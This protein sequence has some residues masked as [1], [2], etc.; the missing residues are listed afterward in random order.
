MAYRRLKTQKI[1]ILSFLTVIFIS[2]ILAAQQNSEFKIYPKYPDRARPNDL[3]TNILNPERELWIGGIMVYRLTDTGTQQTLPLSAL[4]DTVTI[5][6]HVYDNKEKVELETRTVH[7]V[8][9]D[10]IQYGFNKDIEFNN[11]SLN[12]HY[13]FIIEAER[14]NGDI[15][16]S[17]PITYYSDSKYRMSHAILGRTL[18]GIL[19]MRSVYDEANGFGKLSFIFLQWM[20]ILAF[21]LII[22]AAWKLRNSRVFPMNKSWLPLLRTS[23]ESRIHEHFDDFSF[24]MNIVENR[25]GNIGNEEE[26]GENER[27]TSG[28][29]SIKYFQQIDADE[30]LKDKKMSIYQKWYALIIKN[31]YDLDCEIRKEFRNKSEFE[32][33]ALQIWQHN[34][35]TQII[36]DLIDRLNTETCKVLIMRRFFKKSDKSSSSSKNQLA[37]AEYP[38]GRIFRAG[39][40]NYEQGGLKWMEVSDEIDRAMQNR[41]ESELNDLENESRVSRLW[42]ISTAAPMVGLFGTAVGISQSFKDLKGITDNSEV[43]QRLSG[44]ILSALWTTIIGLLLALITMFAYYQFSNKLETIRSK[45]KHLF[46]DISEKI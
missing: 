33:R 22:R 26:T 8:K 45:W 28:R 3:I 29:H 14:K 34:K 27:K 4:K 2:G 31:R 30:I 21:F 35:S 18:P 5:T 25:G 19:G 11:L 42:N 9:Y 32:D 12:R 37:F 20:T 10:S 1:L 6:M 36:Q 41:A 16:Q 24:K 15:L 13:Q 38:T 23:Y 46:L 17:E 7:V 44:G 40:D 43:I 39:L